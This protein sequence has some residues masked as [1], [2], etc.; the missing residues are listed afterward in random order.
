MNYQTQMAWL[1]LTGSSSSQATHE[2][3]RAMTQD[4]IRGHAE[5]D[6][7]E[8]LAAR[9]T[10]WLEG[11]EDHLLDLKIG[12]PYCQTHGWVA[13]LVRHAF[14]AVDVYDLADS[15]LAAADDGPGE[16]V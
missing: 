8:E 15:L 11:V 10:G 7:R 16:E 6:R 5:D 14:D 1:A 9:L 2:L 4:V 12:R 13:D 3:W